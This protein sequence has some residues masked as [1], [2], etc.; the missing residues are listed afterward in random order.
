ML[1]SI[2]MNTPDLPPPSLWNEVEK[3]NKSPNYKDHNSDG[4]WIELLAM[5]DH[6]SGAIANGSAEKGGP[7]SASEFHNVVGIR[8][9]VFI[10][11]RNS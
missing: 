3:I 5:D 6:W 9:P 7:H 4:Q 1:A 8:L 2:A 11:K 10:D